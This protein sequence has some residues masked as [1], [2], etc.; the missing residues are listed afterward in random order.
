MLREASPKP[1]KPSLAPLSLSKTLSLTQSNYQPYTPSCKPSPSSKMWISTK[2]PPTPP[3]PPTSS[4]SP[5]LDTPRAI[6]S[7]Y[8]MEKSGRSKE[9]WEL[10]KAK[11]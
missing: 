2:V 8:V 5:S 7:G 11:S 1:K 6:L 3:G 10:Y 4:Q 9:Q